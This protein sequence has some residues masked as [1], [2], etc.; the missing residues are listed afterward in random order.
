MRHVI[1]LTIVLACFWWL[2]SGL[3]HLLMLSLAAASIILVVWICHRMDV[4]DHQL[5]PVHLS[6]GFP[7]YLVW[8]AKE[9]IVSNITVVKHVWLGNQSISP[10][11]EKIKMGQRT[12]IGKV[13]FANSITLTPGTV[14]VELEGDEALVHGLLRENVEDLKDGEMNSRICRLEE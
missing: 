5:D 8:L 9:V 7:G 2:N 3:A 11:L 14:T 1:S 6:P 12:D 4:V 10:T 13:I